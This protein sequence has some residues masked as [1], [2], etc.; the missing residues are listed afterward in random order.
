MRFPK[1]LPSALSFKSNAQ[2]RNDQR[3]PLAI[4]A[5]EDRQML[6]ST[7]SI[8]AAG[9]VGDE[10][11]DLIINGEVVQTFTDVGGDP[12]SRAFNQFDFTSDRTISADDIQISFINDAFDQR[13]G[14][15]RNLLVDGFILDGVEFETENPAVFSTGFFA[16]DGFTGPGFL[17]T[18][19]LN[20]NGTFSFSSAGATG[21][22]VTPVR[23]PVTRIRVDAA[24][25][26]GGELIA[27]EVG[28][29]PIETFQLTR[30]T[31]SF[32]V[33]VDQPVSVTAIGIRFL[34]DSF[35]ASTG[36]DRNVTVSNVQAIDLET[37]F[38]E[39]VRLDNNIRVFSTG[40]FLE[41]DGIVAGHGRGNTLNTN[42]VFRFGAPD[43][44]PGD[45]P[46]F[47][48]SPLA[49][50]AESETVTALPPQED[51]VLRF[52]F[53]DDDDLAPIFA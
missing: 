4:E 22:P 36:F 52:S 2:A 37:G 31:Q 16:A 40:T 32:L 46:T 12:D 53:D 5:L 10:A 1:L 49:V 8:F 24:G 43:N 30:S 38:R 3:H 6:S 44:A 19:L 21:G 18:E 35:N 11:F 20:T 14:F 29:V 34:N 50:A 51:E 13:T 48:T 23:D 27:V 28:G 39:V 17:E 47:A 26:E 33:E 7:V 15:D 9:D 45:N 41:A 25:S 42:G